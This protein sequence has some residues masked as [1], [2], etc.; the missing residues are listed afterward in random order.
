MHRWHNSSAWWTRRRTGAIAGRQWSGPSPADTPQV[1]RRIGSRLWGRK[2]VRT[3]DW[4]SLARCCEPVFG[5]CEYQ[6]V[7]LSSRQLQLWHT[8]LINGSLLPVSDHS[9]SH[10]NSLQI[11]NQF[12]LGE[13]SF[14]RKTFEVVWNLSNKHQGLRSQGLIVFVYLD[15]GPGRVVLVV[16]E[17]VA[18]V[19]ELSFGTVRHDEV[20]NFAIKWTAFSRGTKYEQSKSLPDFI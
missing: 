9:A 19:V 1:R 2:G 5:S 8:D 7:L 10:Q 11:L 13:Q 20:V 16:V 17:A 4:C 12:L 6:I 3:A 14:D 18:R 15:R